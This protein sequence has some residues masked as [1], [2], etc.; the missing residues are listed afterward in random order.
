MMSLSTSLT[1]ERL[2]TSFKRDSNGLLRKRVAC[3]KEMDFNGVDQLSYRSVAHKRNI[4]P[5]K[6]LNKKKKKKKLPKHAGSIYE[7]HD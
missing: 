7:L 5:G 3:Q 6:S 4:I 1:L 2:H